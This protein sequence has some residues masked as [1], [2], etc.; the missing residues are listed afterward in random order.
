MYHVSAQGVDE[1]MINVNYYYYLKLRKVCLFYKE[2]FKGASVP[3][4]ESDFAVGKLSSEQR[5]YQNSDPGEDRQY[6]GCQRQ[7]REKL[8][9]D[10]WRRERISPNLMTEDIG[11]NL[12]GPNL[13][14]EDIGPNLTTEP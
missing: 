5:G 10:H 13:T 11:P 9:S 4:A 12:I 3:P 6:V 8:I 14:T 2:P 1:R 7:T